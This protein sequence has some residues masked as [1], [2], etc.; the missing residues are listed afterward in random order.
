MEDTL[1]PNK[2]ETVDSKIT[3]F[4]ILSVQKSKMM[5]IIDEFKIKGFQNIQKKI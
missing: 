1:T 3:N 2:S 4:S 5:Q